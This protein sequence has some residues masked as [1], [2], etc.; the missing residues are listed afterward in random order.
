MAQQPIA[1]SVTSLGPH[2]WNTM[3]PCLGV[4]GCTEPFFR[5]NINFRAGTLEFGNVNGHHG[6]RGGHR[7]NGGF[8][9]GYVYS[10]P[11]YVPYP[12]AVP[13]DAYAPEEPIDE[14][15]APAPTIFEN[16]REYRPA[17]NPTLTGDAAADSRYGEHYLDSR[18]QRPARP[19]PAEQATS[20][21]EM[22]PTSR[23]IIPVLLVFKDGH[24]QEIGNYAIVGDTLYDLG[25]FVAH[26][27][28]LADLDLQQ[29]VEKNEQRGV[30][31]NLPAS[32]KPKA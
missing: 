31:F 32:L 18:E 12:V 15:Q 1:P 9:G 16:R 17:P 28:K 19:E 26:K 13:E 8:R 29:T 23:E 10:Y 24:Q 22:S 2:G 20:H 14:E 21:H 30:E 5:P 4:Q 25:T 7:H 6:G 11:Y 27:I 3:G